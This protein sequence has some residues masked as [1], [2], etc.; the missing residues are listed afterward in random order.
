[1]K[2]DSGHPCLTPRTALKKAEGLPFMRGAIQGEVIQACTCLMKA[3]GNPSFFITKM[4]KACLNLS[5]A[6]ARSSLMAIPG[7][8]LLLL[9]CMAS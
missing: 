6:L 5:K 8:P 9:E 2:G 7:S 4:M 1:M 3:S